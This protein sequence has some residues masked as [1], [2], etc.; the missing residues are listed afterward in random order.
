MN[1]E[2]LIARSVLNPV[3]PIGVGTPEVENL[4]SYFCRLAL[5]HCVSTVHLGRKVVAAMQ[6]QFSENHTWRF[7]NLSGM[8]DATEDWARA[9]SAMTSVANLESL[10]MRPWRDVIAEQSPRVA[11]PRW[12]PQ[13]LHEDRATGTTPYFRLA[14][15]VGTV[16]ACSR[17]KCRLAQLCPDCGG[18]NTR[19]NSAFVV[20]GWCTS[21]SCGA[22]LGGFERIEPA[23]PAENWIASQVGAMLAIQSAFASMPTRKALLDGIRE[24]VKRLDDGKS[25]IFA[26]RIGLA[27]TTVHHWLQEG[28]IP[29]LPALLRIASQT[30]LA[31]PKLVTGNLAD[32][33]PA[34]AEVHE[35]ESLFPNTK[36]RPPRQC[37]DWD[38]IR[39]E[40]VALNESSAALS[41]S[42]VARKLNISRRMINLKANKEAQM[43]AERWAEHRRRRAEQNRKN[44]SDLIE[45][46][47]PEIVAKGKAIN[48]REIM[49]HVSEEDARKCRDVFKLLQEIKHRGNSA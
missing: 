15:D 14:W 9:L 5:S 36:K 47:Y 30:G 4:I 12:C 39:A 38:R 27:K 42:D 26:R 19:H 31:L 18:A 32:W 21:A 35:L 10:T 23:T 33:P 45:R 43:L 22:F 24:L 34:A 44:T 40:M 2:L 46:I 6:W 16:T 11:S 49:A 8:S 48:L 3:A 29:A 7:A 25:A 20:P 41:V 17:H 1:E 13:C 28:G 37:Y